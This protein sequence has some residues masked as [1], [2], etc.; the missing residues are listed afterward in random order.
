MESLRLSLDNANTELQSLEAEN[1]KL[2]QAHPERAS[3]VD[4]LSEL[5]EEAL[6]DIQRK[7]EQAEDSRRRLEETTKTLAR[8][9]VHILCQVLP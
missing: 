6:R 5:Y 2:R 9:E 4:L 7:E 1:L 8:A 3:E